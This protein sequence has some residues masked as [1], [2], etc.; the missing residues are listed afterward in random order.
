MRR[1]NTIM[2][3]GLALL[4][5]GIK[6]DPEIAPIPDEAG[7]EPVR[8]ETGQVAMDDVWHFQVPPGRPQIKRGP[9]PKPPSTNLYTRAGRAKTAE[10]RRIIPGID[11]D[12]IKGMLRNEGAAWERASDLL[13]KAYGS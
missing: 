13:K 10:L 4:C 3:A 12:T 2:S 1:L 11:L 9:L 6:P 7:P 5:S 8:G